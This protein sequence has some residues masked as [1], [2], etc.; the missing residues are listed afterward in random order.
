MSRLA[1]IGFLERIRA[2]TWPVLGLAAAAYFGATIFINA[3]L[4]QGRISDALGS[5]YRASD[6]FVNPSMVGG[7]VQLVLLGIV[8]F[9]VGRL[10][11][12]DVGWQRSAAWQGLLI[13]L[14]FWI[15]AQGV[16]AA[17]TAIRGD[18][19][20]VEF[21]NRPGWIAVTGLFVGQFF[22]NALVEE[23][24]C[25]GFFLPQFY[26][27]A[28]RTFPPRA[29][30][31]IAA[32]G[33]SVFFA[34]TH[35]PNRFLI[36]NSGASNLLIDQIGLVIGGLIFAA[37]YLVT[38]NLFIAI[39]LHSLMNLAPTATLV[40]SPLLLRHGVW[41]GLT[42]LLLLT[43]PQIQ[44]YIDRDGMDDDGVAIDATHEEA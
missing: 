13:T 34:L 30:L 5:L 2:T 43:W 10:R 29:A 16:L 11:F 6:F 8:V 42:V 22:G 35:I 37:V 19:A 12:S 21:W 25:R 36:R 40:E 26:L 38:R 9:A 27:M 31:T 24:G 33:S 4:Y 15:A 23:T 41:F 44:R 18:L 7:L 32:L 3:V 14:G 17:I 39:G 1:A 20:L 28:N